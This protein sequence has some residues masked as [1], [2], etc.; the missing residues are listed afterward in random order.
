VPEVV[1]RIVA[2]RQ[3][4]HGTVQVVQTEKREDASVHG[5]PAAKE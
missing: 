5:A 4:C 3:L 2:Y 1:A